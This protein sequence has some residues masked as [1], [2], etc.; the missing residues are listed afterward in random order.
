MTKLRRLLHHLVA[1]EFAVRLH[2]IMLILWL[3]P[4]TAVTLLWLANSVAFV[5]WLSLYALV[6]GHWSSLQAALA[7]RRV[8]DGNDDG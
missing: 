3:V 1:P 7:E 2:A 5:A 8:K 4:G 6:I